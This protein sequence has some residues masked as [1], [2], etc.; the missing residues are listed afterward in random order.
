M[1]YVPLYRFNI[2]SSYTHFSY[3]RVV[4]LMSVMFEEK[5]V[6]SVIV[7][8]VGNTAWQML[9]TT[10]MLNTFQQDSQV[11]DGWCFSMVHC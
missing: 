7:F 9:L 1:K 8:T 5:F 10:I 4:F 3:I 2:C 11:P 6:F